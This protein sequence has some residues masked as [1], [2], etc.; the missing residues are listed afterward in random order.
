MKT[1]LTSLFALFIA[2]SALANNRFPVGYDVV[3]EE[4]QEDY[5]KAM[6][7]AFANQ[8]KVV[9]ACDSRWVQAV[10]YYPDEILLAKQSAQPLLMYNRLD[11]QDHRIMYRLSVATQTD[12]KTIK[13]VRA[14]VFA[15]EES[16]TGD[17]ANPIYTEDY[18]L[19]SDVVCT[20]N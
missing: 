1:V 15:L 9:Q 20:V 5:I 16:N 7:Q 3:P 12:L 10:L 13:Q 14:Q 6:A 8:P 4:R 11:L 19:K 17:L 18:V 2:T